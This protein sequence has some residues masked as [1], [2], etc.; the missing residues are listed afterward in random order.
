MMVTIALANF[1]VSTTEVAVTVTCGGLG[2]VV[3]AVY[4]PLVV[5]VPHAVPVQPLPLTLHVTA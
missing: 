5:T 4:R 2:M 3:G 1:V